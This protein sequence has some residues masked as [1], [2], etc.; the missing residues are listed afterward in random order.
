ML[1]KNK[2]L[3]L[4]ICTEI[5]AATREYSAIEI[6]QLVIHSLLIDMGYLG[7]RLVGRVGNS[8]LR[9]MKRKKRRFSACEGE[10]EKNQAQVDRDF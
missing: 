8:I 7:G 1:D 2:L 6:R 3:L 9:H 5:D 10:K 4:G